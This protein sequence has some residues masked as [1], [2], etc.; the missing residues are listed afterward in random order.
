MYTLFILTI[1][2]LC[3]QAGTGV[4]QSIVLQIGFSW[5]SSTV[6]SCS[7]NYLNLKLT[8]AKTII[9]IS[10]VMLCLSFIL[11]V[12]LFSTLLIGFI[13]FVSLTSE[14]DKV[15]KLHMTQQKTIYDPYFTYRKV[16]T[17][18]I[19]YSVAAIT[20]IVHFASFLSYTIEKTACEGTLPT[21]P[22][23]IASLSG[24]SCIFLFVCFIFLMMIILRMHRYFEGEDS[25]EEEKSI[26][27]E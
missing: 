5:E 19:L 13:R 4:Y 26:K 25:V 17:L 10:F 11:V 7:Q 9:S 23:V 24:C 27:K 1:I 21:E 22:V 15:E 3:L 16:A 14:Y 18:Y 8:Q 6:T 2:V 20:N 12:S